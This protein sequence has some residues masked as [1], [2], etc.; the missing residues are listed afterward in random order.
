MPEGIRFKVTEEEYKFFHRYAYSK[1]TDLGSLCCELLH[2]AAQADG[3]TEEKASG[4][5][6]TYATPAGQAARRGEEKRKAEG[7]PRKKAPRKA[8]GIYVEKSKYEFYKA[9]AKEHGI[10]F[11]ELVRR[12]VYYSMEKHGFD[13]DDP[14]LKN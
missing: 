2:K 9:F 5:P 12:A 4:I 14:Y 13:P 6:L 11:A 8:V 3:F 1:G 7:R 10:S